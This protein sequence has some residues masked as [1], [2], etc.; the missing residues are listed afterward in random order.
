LHR[1][2]YCRKCPL[3]VAAELTDATVRSHAS[4]CGNAFPLDSDGSIAIAKFPDEDRTPERDGLGKVA[5]DL[6]RA[7]KIAFRFRVLRMG[8]R[9]AAC[10]GRF[11]RRGGARADKPRAM[12]CSKPAMVAQ[13]SYSR[14]PR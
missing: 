14:S 13:R 5:L 6:A 9:H 2:F 8:D 12:R 11:D 4:W 1:R 3:A 10:R 7:A